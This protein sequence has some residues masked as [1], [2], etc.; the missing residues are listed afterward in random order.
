MRDL[1]SPSR[2]TNVVDVG[3]NPYGS[4]LPYLPMLRAG[5][6]HLTGFEPE[7]EAFLLLQGTC[8]PN[9]SYLPYAL[10]DGNRHILHVCTPASGM[11][12]LFEPDPL[13]IRLF[14]GFEAFSEVTQRIPLD[15]RR[16]DDLEE[17]T[18]IDFLKIDVQGS[19]LAV[20]QNGRNKLSETVAVQAEVSF[21]TLYK[22]QPPFG[23]VDLELRRQ[24]FIP[25]CFVGVKSWPIGEFMV[26]NDPRRPL[27]Q[28]LEAD[29]VYVR[30]VTRP[31]TLSDEQLKHLAL[32]AHHCY[33]SFDLAH[34]CVRLLED[35]RAVEAGSGQRYLETLNARTPPWTEPM[36]WRN[37]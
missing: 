33:G 32:I 4:D 23:E 25:H 3:A 2:I 24:G 9:E 11:T 8:G 15:T 28:L 35:R 20:F 5:L 17:I 16:L 1:L 29:I 21:V 12:S 22:N 37:Q 34:V 27:N 13:T 10:G 36:A 30:D 18:H 6:C 14:R 31:S 26:G 7:P 19:E